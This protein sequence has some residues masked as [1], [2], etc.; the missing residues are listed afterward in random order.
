[1]PHAREGI[2]RFCTKGKEKLFSGGQI[3][4]RG[5][6]RAAADLSGC[7]YKNKELF[8]G[9]EPVRVRRVSKRRLRKKPSGMK[10]KFR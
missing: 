8:C 4:C 5:N 10:D 7:I 2:I 9:S 6:V 1:M 3:A